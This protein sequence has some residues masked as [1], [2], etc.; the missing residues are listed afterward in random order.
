MK[1]TLH[2]SINICFIYIQTLSQTIHTY[3]KV[4]KF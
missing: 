2:F 1:V 4:V 3:S